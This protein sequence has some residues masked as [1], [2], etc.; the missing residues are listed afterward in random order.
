LSSHPNLPKRVAA[1]L[2]AGV[3]IPARSHWVANGTA[4]AA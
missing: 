2:K 4:A 3:A 1:L